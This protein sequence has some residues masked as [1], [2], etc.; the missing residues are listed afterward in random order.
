MGQ[1]FWVISFEIK[2]K[3]IISFFSLQSLHLL[4]VSVQNGR[5]IVY[6]Y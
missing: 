3:A 4:D 2:L 1:L 5:R 6:N